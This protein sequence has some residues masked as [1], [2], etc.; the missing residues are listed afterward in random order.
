MSIEQTIEFLIDKRISMARFGDGEFLYIVDKLD[1]PFQ[2]YDRQLADSLSN[3][4]KTDSQRLLVGL[5]S[6]YHGLENLTEEGKLFWRSQISWVFPRL[7]RFINRSRTY[8]NASITRLY[9]EINDKELSRRYFEQ[10]KRLW[11]GREL[12]IIEGEKSRLGIGND[13]FV[14]ASAIE[15]ILGPVHNAYEKVNEIIEKAC[16][17]ST[18]KLILLA[19]GPTAKVI[20]SELSSRGYQAIDIGNID[21]EY[22]WF[23]RGV[24]EKQRI[25]GKYTSEAVGGRIVE[26]FESDIYDRQISARVL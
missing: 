16:T 18:N 9:Y 1:L 5:P 4:L 8:G 12:L 7:Y 14:N 10:I 21:I 6:G 24:T 3:I 26:D 17:F 2:K 15:R 11:Q 22:E 23:I 20:A 19:L 25:P 13:L